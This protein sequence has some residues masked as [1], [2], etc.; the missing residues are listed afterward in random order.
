MKGRREKYPGGLSVMLMNGL[1][2]VVVL[3]ALLLIFGV[4]VDSAC[5]CANCSTNGRSFKRVTTLVA[6]DSTCCGSKEPAHDCTALGI[7]AVW[8]GAV[9]KGEGAKTGND[10]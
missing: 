2:T 1:V 10:K 3:A 4:A 7:R 5:T 9:G 6:D 8:L